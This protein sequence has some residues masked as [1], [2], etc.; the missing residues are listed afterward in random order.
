MVISS[1]RAAPFT[2]ASCGEST[3]QSAGQGCNGQCARCWCSWRPSLLLTSEKPV[4]DPILKIEDDPDLAADPAERC[5]G[6]DVRL[7]ETPPPAEIGELDHGAVHPL[8]ALPALGV[9]D[10]AAGG[11]DIA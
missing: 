8:R 11:A 9:A 5:I 3:A 4:T 7:R 1:F 2:R 10:D 6:R